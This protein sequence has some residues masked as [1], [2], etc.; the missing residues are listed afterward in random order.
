[1]SP[2]RRAGTGQLTGVRDLLL[3]RKHAEPIESEGVPAKRRWRGANCEEVTNQ[4]PVDEAMFFMIDDKYI[5]VQTAGGEYP[6]G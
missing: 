3:A 1:M 6:I 4:I 5:V 2:T